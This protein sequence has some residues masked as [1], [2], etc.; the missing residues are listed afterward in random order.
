M[1]MAVNPVQAMMKATE[2]R[3]ME[4]QTHY[5]YGEHENYGSC[6]LHILSSVLSNVS[7][8]RACGV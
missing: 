2:A 8:A 3:K 4:T 7:M 6:G 1:T 5:T